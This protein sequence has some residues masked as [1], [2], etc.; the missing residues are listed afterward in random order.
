ME[1]LEELVLKDHSV[2]DIKVLLK[3]EKLSEE[4]FLILAKDDNR[5][6]IQSIVKS[7][8]NRR[9]KEELL[10]KKY[11]K[12]NAF[13][14]D[15]RKRGF[16][17]IAGIDEVG[18]GPLAGPVVSAAVILDP[19][20][21]IIGLDDSKKLSEKKRLDLFDKI[22]EYCISYSYTFIGEKLIDELN[23]LEATK[24]S[25]LKSVG[26]LTVKPDLLFIDAIR[27]N[28]N[29]KQIPIVH[30]DARSN[31]IAAASIVAKVIRDEYMKKIHKEF[32]MYNFESNKGYGSKEHTDAI[33]KHGPCRYHRKS[34]IKNFIR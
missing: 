17:F 24:V 12:M 4:D 5:K 33:K 2:N 25:M 29:I 28:T 20:K 16:Q 21:E 8:K 18:R 3:S 1:K 31:S 6:A 34:F 26:K 22:V 13:E 23:I 30:G 15:F 11:K 7:I 32:P 10:F 19:N 9:K 27:I 14:E